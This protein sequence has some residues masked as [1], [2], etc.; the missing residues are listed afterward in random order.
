MLGVFDQRGA[1]VIAGTASTAHPLA[2]S[3]THDGL[4]RYCILAAAHGAGIPPG[5]Y[6]A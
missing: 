6:S 3:A 2:Q 5:E 4:L 1:D